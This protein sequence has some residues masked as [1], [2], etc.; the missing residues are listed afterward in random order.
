MTMTSEEREAL[1]DHLRR[2]SPSPFIDALV[3]VMAA[4]PS[5]E[6]IVK[7]AEQHPDRWG[8]LAKT[9][10]GPVGYRDEVAVEHRII[11][12]HRMSDSQLLA[13]VQE[14]RKALPLPVIEA[15]AAEV[16]EPQWA[17]ANHGP[18]DADLRDAGIKPKN[19]PSKQ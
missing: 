5:E 17:A 6:A 10:S 13:Y 11:D 9:L 8:K 3:V 19:D 12:M 2:T 16:V 7:W 1:R 4:R 15:E 18:S 14:Q